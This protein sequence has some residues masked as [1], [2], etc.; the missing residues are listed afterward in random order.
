MGTQISEETQQPASTSKASSPN[1]PSL[2][3][4][5]LSRINSLQLRF[6]K[7]EADVT[8][9]LAA[10]QML[11]PDDELVSAL[12]L[13]RTSETCPNICEAEGLIFTKLANIRELLTEADQLRHQTLQEL[14]TLLSPQQAAL[15]CLAGYE[16]VF[17]LRSL[18]NASC[19]QVPI[20]IVPSTAIPV[21]VP[22]II[23]EATRSTTAR[24]PLR[25]DSLRLLVPTN[26]EVLPHI[27]PLAAVP[28]RIPLGLASE[29]PFPPL[30]TEAS[31]SEAQLFANAF[32][33]MAES[34]SGVS[35]GPV[36]KSANV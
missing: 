5:Q 19:G 14:F 1:V 9:R 33:V 8:D 22:V 11:I 18:D 16:L 10:I 17:A 31:M 25:P 2:S 4:R 28:V 7:A 23:S 20:P 34:L 12:D 27:P 15:C 24:Q 32:P 35:S 3:E 21:P 26:P 13:K 36:V 30:R 6:R 29:V